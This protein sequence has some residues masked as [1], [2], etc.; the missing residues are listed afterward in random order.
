MTATCDLDFAKQKKVGNYSNN[1]YFQVISKEQ[2]TFDKNFDQLGLGYNSTPM[3]FQFGNKILYI[4]FN[5]QIWKSQEIF[6]I[7]IF[8]KQRN[9]Y[10]ICSSSLQ[11]AYYQSYI[12]EQQ[13]IQQFL[14]QFLIIQFYKYFI[15]VII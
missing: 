3:I 7:M 11:Q 12:F 10:N 14:E 15:Q 8:A 5:Q 9:Q 1:L 13:Q 6:N 2:S 4:N